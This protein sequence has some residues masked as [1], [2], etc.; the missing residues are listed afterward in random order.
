M[1][2]QVER[3][4]GCSTLQADAGVSG[5]GGVSLTGYDPT[6]VSE[7]VKLRLICQTQMAV[8]N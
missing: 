3:Q 6:S 2:L 7:A 5:G 8:S 1:Y 4:A